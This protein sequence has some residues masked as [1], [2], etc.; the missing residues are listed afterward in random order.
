MKTAEWEN[1]SIKGGD[2][3][4][5]IRKIKLS[6]GKDLT[7]LGSGSII[8]KFSDADLIDTYQFMIDPVIIGQ[9]STL[10]YG[11][12]HKLELILVN[13]RVFRSG[14][15]LLTYERMDRH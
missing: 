15:V 2:I 10:F 14:V 13:S 12:R 7:I 4:D 9:G 5:Q 3:V 8:I 11:L 6:Q 1:T